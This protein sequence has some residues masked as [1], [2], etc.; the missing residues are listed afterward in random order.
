MYGPNK[1]TAPIAR[2]TAYDFNCHLS[3]THT[4]DSRVHTAGQAFPANDPESL[5]VMPHEL[6]FEEVNG[7]SARNASRMKAKSSLNGVRL[8]AD[9]VNAINATLLSTLGDE[10]NIDTPEGR[11][12]ILKELKV[13]DDKTVR[14]AIND[15]LNRYLRYVGVAITGISGGMATALQRQGFS[16][17]R[18]GLMTIMHRGNAIPAG[19]RVAM[20][21]DIM[22]ICEA[23][24]GRIAMNHGGS[25]VPHDKILP[26][27]VEVKDSDGAVYDL[28][29]A[30]G[31]QV[32]VENI[33]APGVLMPRASFMLR[34]S[35]PFVPV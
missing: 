26:R 9:A 15:T 24:L 20:Q 16:A 19:A 33:H 1:V 28:H 3:H 7:R 8:A 4:K 13:N 27:L 35:R 34:E 12:N 22:D 31:R 29:A 18:G 32:S 21:F 6:L 23:D 30:M 5:H 10:C 14:D 2:S 25:G 11:T 17:T